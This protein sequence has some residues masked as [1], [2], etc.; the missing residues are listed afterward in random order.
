MPYNHSYTSYSED[1]LS[2]KV[3]SDGNT[4]YDETEIDT[5]IELG[6]KEEDDLIP[7][8]KDGETKIQVHPENLTTWIM[9]AVEDYFFANPGPRYVLNMFTP[10]N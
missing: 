8:N 2:E 4:S 10:S 6:E 9:R 5:E 1:T 3:P 7:K